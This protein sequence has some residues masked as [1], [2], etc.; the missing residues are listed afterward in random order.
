[1]VS[2]TSALS[3]GELACDDPCESAR[4]R[5]LEWHK[6]GHSVVVFFFFFLAVAGAKPLG[7][8]ES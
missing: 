7:S 2:M 3:S 1:M 8:S 4:P 6:M 5:L